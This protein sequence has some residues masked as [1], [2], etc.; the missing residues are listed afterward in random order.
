MSLALG[1]FF[2]RFPVKV[3]CGIARGAWW[4]IYPYSAYWRR[5]GADPAI[6]AVLH[7]YAALPG[8]V[9]W[10][11]GAHYGIYA[12][13]LAR[14]V[15]PAGRVEAFEPDPVSCRRLLWHRCLN[16]LSHLHVHP[17]AAS[18][19][20]TTAR[21]YQYT[22]FGD[23]TSHLPYLNES[24]ESVPYREITTV[25]LDEWVKSGR[26]LPPHFIKIDVEGH[27]GP[28]LEGMRRT[29]AS[30]RPVVLLAIHSQG[31]HASAR[32][33]LGA[34]GYS[35]QPLVA[36]NAA[37]VLANNFGELLCLPASVSPVELTATPPA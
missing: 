4:S 13:G 14:A 32:A 30:A 17:I 3:L 22:K 36:S 35:L 8:I 7:R 18:G 33:T 25:A 9:C 26:I 16:R 19:V 2:G 23:T 27:A 10:D 11:I 12:V 21:L 15:G 5:G 24:I 6:D 37:S 34:L 20:T 28:A 31:E 29:I 1:E